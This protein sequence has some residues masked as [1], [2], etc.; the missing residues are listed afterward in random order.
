MRFLKAKFKNFVGFLTGLGLNEV[1]IDFEKQQHRMCL[2][3][4]RNGSGKSSLMEA[5]TLFPDI[6]SSVRE[7]NGFI[8]K[9][10][11]GKRDG[12]REL[13][14]S[15]GNDTYISACHWINEK[16][17]CFLARVM[18]GGSTVEL[19]ENGNVGS[20]IELLEAIFGLTKEHNRLL[21][22]GAGMKDIVSSPP[23]ERKN[24]ISKFVPNVEEYLETYK[25]SAKYHSK[26][27]NDIGVVS[28]ELH[29][30]GGDKNNIII[31]RDSAL[32]KR[33]L[34]A[35]KLQRLKSLESTVVTTLNAL[36]IGSESVS[37]VY[38]KHVRLNNELCAKLTKLNDSLKE[39]CDA[40]PV[41]NNL[42]TAGYSDIITESRDSLSKLEYQRDTFNTRYGE[43]TDS[44]Q[45]LRTLYENQNLRYS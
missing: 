1:E 2:I 39:T 18:P 22:L 23:S 27:K 41:E 25:K 9:D 17:K 40:I 14:V 31:N 7:A 43:M 26:L 20:Y 11:D 6:Y 8:V 32:K 34:A 24:S 12:Y 45:A 21:F 16:T 15:Q 28:S 42:T 44:L 36:N 5:L 10:K 37:D 38:E 29:R 19:N 35:E 30:L 13:W 3:I 4:G 33:E